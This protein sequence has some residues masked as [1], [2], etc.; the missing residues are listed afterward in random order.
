ML[1]GSRLSVVNLSPKPFGWLRNSIAVVLC[2]PP[3]PRNWV[4]HNTTVYIR[5]RIFAQCGQM[6]VRVCNC[7]RQQNKC[8]DRARR[9]LLHPALAPCNVASHNC[10]SV[11]PHAYNCLSRCTLDRFST[12]FPLY[13]PAPVAALARVCI[14]RKAR[15]VAAVAAR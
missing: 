3:A 10:R 5:N 12:G 7:K 14:S 9:W 13:P 6:P 15:A 2:L 1:W 8:R 4:L 11:F